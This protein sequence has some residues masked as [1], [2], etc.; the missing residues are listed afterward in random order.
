MRAHD[1]TPSDK[2]VEYEI[3]KELKRIGREV[4]PSLRQ[5]KRKRNQRRREQYKVKHPTPSKRG[6]PKQAAGIRVKILEALKEAPATP[7]LLTAK[8]KANPKTVAS[9]L[10]RLALAG[11]IVSQYG[12]YALSPASI[13]TGQPQKPAHAAPPT[14]PKPKLRPFGA[15]QAE[16]LPGPCGTPEAD[17][18]GLEDFLREMNLT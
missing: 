10:R 11:E 6:R 18:G 16:D 17:P 7:A 15:A 9:A 12:M 13:A 4:Q 1:R 2:E 14:G 3:G 5:A 8:L